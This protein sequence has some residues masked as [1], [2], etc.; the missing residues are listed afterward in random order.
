MPRCPSCKQV[1]ADHMQIFCLNDG[2]RLVS[3]Q[4]S[5][6]PQKTVLAPPP[7]QTDPTLPPTQYVRTPYNQTPPQWPQGQ[8][9]QQWSPPPG[10][11][12]GGYYP[13]PGQYAPYARGP[14]AQSGQPIEATLSLVFG[15]LSAFFGL[16]GVFGLG[17][18][19]WP[20]FLFGAAGLVLAIVALNK[21]TMRGLSL[22]GL[23]T[24]I[25]GLIMFLIRLF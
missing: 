4:S 25:F 2:S 5:Y 10:P 20:A 14:Y 11:N 18:L 23:S 13:Q 1:Y 12:W 9:P 22:G 21:A 8:P 7:R 3:D 17:I 6:D 19:M 15:C 24:S 16:L